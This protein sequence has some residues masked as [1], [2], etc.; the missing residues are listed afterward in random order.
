MDEKW[1][2]GGSDLDSEQNPYQS[3]DQLVIALDFGTTFS[4]IAYAFPN[5]D[6]LDIIPIHDW[7]GRTLM[8]AQDPLKHMLTS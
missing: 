6:K 1:K 5:D 4:G 7:P 3:E 2:E 8:R